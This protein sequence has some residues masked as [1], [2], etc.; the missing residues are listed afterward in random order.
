MPSSRVT[1]RPPPARAFS[2]FPNVPATRTSSSAAACSRPVLMFTRAEARALGPFPRFH[3]SDFRVRSLD[4]VPT[5]PIRYE[6][7]ILLRPERPQIGSRLPAIPQPTPLAPPQ[8][9]P[10]L[11]TCR[12]VV[13][14][15]RS[16]VALWP[17]TAPS[18][19]ATTTP[20]LLH[21]CGAQLVVRGR[22]GLAT[23]YCQGARRGRVATGARAG[24]HGGTRGGAPR[25]CLLRPAGRPREQLAGRGRCCNGV[26]AAAAAQLAVRLFPTAWHQ[27]PGR[28]PPWSTEPLPRSSSTN[29][30]GHV[31]ITG[32]PCFSHS[33]LTDTSRAACGLFARV[34]AHGPRLAAWGDVGRCP[35]AP[36]TIARC[37]G[38]RH[39]WH[40]GHG[41]DLRRSHPWSW[42]GGEG[43]SL[44]GPA[45]SLHLRRNRLRCRA[46]GARGAPGA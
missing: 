23:P 8:L 44:S 45:G 17:P 3:S 36:S 34:Y 4:G 37:A 16:W 43:P 14:G 25:A 41:R 6:D 13:R 18:S 31:G 20:P 38:G 27:W 30:A 29:I 28:P 42:I 11:A 12:A 35:G 24:D 2:L 7:P 9:R 10:A 32:N 1:S 21:F 33:S 22:R 46:R 26:D 40:R 15:F 5:L 19:P 39:T